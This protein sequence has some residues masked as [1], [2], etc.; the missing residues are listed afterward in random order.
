M[1]ACAA[2]WAALWHR[3]SSRSRSRPARPACKCNVEPERSDKEIAVALGI[4]LGTVKR[5][6]ANLFAKLNVNRR[7]EAVVRAEE[8][9]LLQTAPRI[10]LTP[11]L[12]PGYSL[13][14]FL[15]TQDSRHDRYRARPREYPFAPLGPA[16]HR[17]ARRQFTRPADGRFDHP[18]RHQPGHLRLWRS[19]RWRQHELCADAQEPHARREPVQRRPAFSARSSSSAITRGRAAASAASRWR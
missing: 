12:E 4:S 13:R 2:L 6:S 19:A 10:G 11:Y 5:H 1:A 8:L 14:G 15:R 18:H 16:H 3:P 17:P 7:W 9:A